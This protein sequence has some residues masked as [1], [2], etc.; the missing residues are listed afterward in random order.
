[1][2]YVDAHTL[3]AMELTEA[4][5]FDQAIE[6]LEQAL[7]YP[8]NLEVGK[9]SDDEKNALIYHQMGLTYE[10][11]GNSKKAKEFY[12]KSATSQNNRGMYDLIYFKAKSEEK[13][14][15][16]DKANSMY[17]GLVDKARELRTGGTSNTLVAVEEASSLN[18]KAVSNSY[19]LEALGQK[20]LGETQKSR[21]L[22]ESSLKAYKNNLWANV[23]ME[24]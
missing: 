23:M 21:E 9:A 14:G 20:G 1:W 4:K 7:L 15:N 24:N 12:K 10:K 19:Y 16:T 2:R 13:L 3:K 6:H 22:L 18:N 5:Q 8:E 11:M 17:Q